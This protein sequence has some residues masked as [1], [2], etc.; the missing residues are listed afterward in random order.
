MDSRG[1]VRVADGPTDSVM[2]HSRGIRTFPYAQ[3]QSST[4]AGARLLPP[5][6]R[7][8]LT[9]SAGRAG[10]EVVVVG[11]GMYVD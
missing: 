10:D 9:R 1:A 6:L 3:H 4:A 2:C 5:R 11:S 7:E 8:T